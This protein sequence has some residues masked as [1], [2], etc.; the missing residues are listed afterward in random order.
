MHSGRVIHEEH[1]SVQSGVIQPRHALAPQAQDLPQRTDLTFN[2]L[3][4]ST[5]AAPP[6]GDNVD[7]FAPLSNFL[8]DPQYVDMDRIISFQDSFMR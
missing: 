4:P 5:D 8:L 6:L 7:G 3:F 2:E 1:A